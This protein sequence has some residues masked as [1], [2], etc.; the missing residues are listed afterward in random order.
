MS[1]LLL[2][3]EEE[4]IILKRRQRESRKINKRAIAQSLRELYDLSLALPDR[5]PEKMIKFEDCQQKYDQM[6][7]ALQ[8]IQKNPL[9]VHSRLVAKLIKNGW[10]VYG[11]SNTSIG[12][13]RICVNHYTT[14]GDFTIENYYDIA[15]SDYADTVLWNNPKVGLISLDRDGYPYIYTEIPFCQTRLQLSDTD[16]NTGVFDVA[17]I[18][19]RCI[20][21]H[22]VYN[23]SQ[24][25]RNFVSGTFKNYKDFDWWSLMNHYH[26]S[27]SITTGSLK[28]LSIKDLLKLSRK[29]FKKTIQNALQNNKEE[30]T[31]LQALLKECK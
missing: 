23:S 27:S 18:H 25:L 14:P 5:L 26:I 29:Q 24:D 21:R 22:S 2:T 10:T 16:N 9:L 20:Y 19:N 15:A 3:E 13:T 8:P 12:K 30:N 28:A 6:L 7:A 31:V 4:R 1:N 11:S 17:V